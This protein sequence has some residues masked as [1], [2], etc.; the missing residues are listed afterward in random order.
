MEDAALGNTRAL[1]DELC[2][3]LKKDT[4]FALESLLLK[5]NSKSTNHVNILAQYPKYKLHKVYL[6]ALTLTP[7]PKVQS[8]VPWTP[9]TEEIVNRYL[10]KSSWKC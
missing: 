4:P 10:S 1:D 9:T 6:F 7:S 2:C 3:P 5:K 8:R